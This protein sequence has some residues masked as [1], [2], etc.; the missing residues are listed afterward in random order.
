MVNAALAQQNITWTGAGNGNDWETPGNWSSNT[1]PGASD[2]VYIPYQVGNSIVYTVNISSNVTVA[3]LDVEAKG[4]YINSG[5][6]TINDTNVQNI[7][8]ALATFGPSTY[9]HIGSTQPAS[10]IIPKGVICK[11]KGNTITINS[12]SELVNN[13]YF[14]IESDY[15]TTLTLTNGLGLFINNGQL[16][17]GSPGKTPTVQIT[18]DSLV[19]NGILQNA[20]G[21]LTVK[22]NTYFKGGS[23]IANDS[24]S[25]SLQYGRDFM[26]RI[27]F[28][29]VR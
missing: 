29:L 16:W 25:I 5:S 9:V 15:T 4:L 24:T 28:V 22:S 23:L 1:V 14:Q 7:F 6:L 11:Y 13:G 26:L 21:A 3:K 27:H 18:N 19:N 20:F 17:R 2:T 8:Y 12:G 10:L